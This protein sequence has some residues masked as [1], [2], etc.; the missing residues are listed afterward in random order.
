MILLNTGA[1]PVQSWKHG[2]LCLTSI[3][4]ILHQKPPKSNIKRS[5]AN[6]VVVKNTNTLSG[7]K[8]NQRAG[9]AAGNGWK[10]V[11]RASITK[12]G[13]EAAGIGT[14]SKAHAHSFY[15]S[16]QVIIEHVD[17]S[18]DEVTTGRNLNERIRAGRTWDS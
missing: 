4:Q 17:V 9:K 5:L 8:N 6:G 15:R 2:T 18:D 11:I 1:A 14:R 3:S 16:A 10:R 12:R 7:P 13:R